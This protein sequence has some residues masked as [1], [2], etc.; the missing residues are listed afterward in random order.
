MVLL[1]EVESLAPTTEV[2]ANETMQLFEGL[3][4]GHQSLMERRQALET[5]LRA[6]NEQL[7]DCE[8]RSGRVH[9]LLGEEVG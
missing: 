9:A 1:A 6:V 4:A 8:Q 7:D 3:V 2:D 5:E